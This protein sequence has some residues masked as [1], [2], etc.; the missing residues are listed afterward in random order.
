[1]CGLD[2]HPDSWVIAQLCGANHLGHEVSLILEQNCFVRCSVSVTGCHVL[3]P[4]HN[5]PVREA[6]WLYIVALCPKMKLDLY[7]LDGF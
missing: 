3:C 7:T 5:A 4:G 2:L 6:Q 1:M